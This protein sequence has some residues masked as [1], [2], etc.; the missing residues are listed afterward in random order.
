MDL[1]ILSQSPASTVSHNS[2]LN[3]VLKSAPTSKRSAP[4]PHDISKEARVLAD[5]NHPG[6]IALLDT[7]T[8]DDGNLAYYMPY[9]PI[10]LIDL[11]ETTAFSPHPFTASFN[12]ARDPEREERFFTIARSITIQALFALTYLHAHDIAHRD[13]K[14]ENFLISHDGYVK[15]IDFGISYQ[16]NREPDPRNI[17]T[18]PR[19]K[20]YFEVCTG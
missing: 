14:P 7:F 2:A 16:V 15:L 9:M 8:D 17:W 3:L 4:E 10:R 13:I 19:D 18:E 1:A 6:I 20:L 12:P 11:L 5:L